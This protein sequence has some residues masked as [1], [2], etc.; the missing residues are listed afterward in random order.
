MAGQVCTAAQRVLVHESVEEVFMAAFL[1]R[2]AELRVGDPLDERT[3]MGPVLNDR[4]VEK[5]Q[6]HVDDAL[7]KGATVQ[8]FGEASGRLYP[9]TVLSGVTQD[10]LVARE[11]AFG[12]VAAVMTYATVEE[13]IATANDTVYGLN[14]AVFT[15]SMRDSWRFIDALQHGTV[16]IN[17]STNYWDQLAPF[18]GAKAS[19]IG[20]ELSTDALLSFTEKKTVVLNVG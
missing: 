5:V 6:A 13:A 7:A 9:P 8:Q 19:G 4:A 15:Q 3:D 18:G 10:M 14:A 20:R 17:E 11:E 16:L 1:A 12:P 2:V